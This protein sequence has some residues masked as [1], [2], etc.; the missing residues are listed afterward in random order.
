[1]KIRV[2]VISDT[3][4]MLRPQVPEYLKDCDYILHAGDVTDEHLLDSIRFMGRLYVVRGNCDG[5]WAEKLQLRQDFRIGELQFLMVHDGRYAGPGAAWAD[6]VISGHTH[7]FACDREGGR[8]YLNP[9]TCGRPRF[10]N[11]VTM[12]LLEIEGRG[13]SVQRVDLM[14]GKV[15]EVWTGIL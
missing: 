2:G 14:T 12:A 9:G 1:M 15:T 13:I 11:E 8:L 10:G 5:R 3:H 7:H 6:V 4:G